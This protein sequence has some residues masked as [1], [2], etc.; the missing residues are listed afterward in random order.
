MGIGFERAGEIGRIVG[1][2][3]MGVE[4]V[5]DGEAEG[6]DGGGIGVGDIEDAEWDHD[7]EEIME[8]NRPTQDS[9]LL[10]LLI[11]FFYFSSH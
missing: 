6:V 3:D 1:M 9:W 7:A 8:E 10:R 11:T 5:G 4:E 2:G